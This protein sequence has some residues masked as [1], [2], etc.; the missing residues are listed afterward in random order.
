MVMLST[1][2]VAIL[3]ANS[4][5][6]QYRALFNSASQSNLII[7]NLVQRL[8]LSY[9]KKVRPISGINKNVIE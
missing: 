8:K 1:A 2:K 9:G 7:T 4:E 3:R 6:Q 5:K